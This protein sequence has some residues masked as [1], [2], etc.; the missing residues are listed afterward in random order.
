LDP[1]RIAA[2][3]GETL[4]VVVKDQL[5]HQHGSPV[6]PSISKQIQ[7]QAA[8]LPKHN[9]TAAMQASSVIPTSRF[10]PT[11]GY[12]P[13]F[14]NHLA[15]SPS[16]GHSSVSATLKSQDKELL[17]KRAKEAMRLF[18]IHIDLDKLSSQGDGPPRDFLKA[19]KCY[20]ENARKGRA[21]A[22]MCV[23]NLFLEGQDVQQ[24]SSVAMGWYLK[25]ASLGDTNAL[26][27][28]EQLRV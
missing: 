21:L 12:V 14:R 6:Q 22:S 19:L 16:S 24:N 3:R 25:A 28:A 9:P 7:Q 17:H 15:M 5:V 18:A 23:G 13:H 10:T 1:L 26:R 20:L 8:R 27:K 11:N 4:D 2:V